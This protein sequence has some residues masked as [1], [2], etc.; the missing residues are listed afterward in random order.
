L[1]PLARSR[2]LIIGPYNKLVRYKV[3][4]PQDIRAWLRIEVARIRTPG[5]YRIIG[6][7][8]HVDFLDIAD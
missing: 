4:G 8:L 5:S 1:P 6:M 7:D 2:G 3:S